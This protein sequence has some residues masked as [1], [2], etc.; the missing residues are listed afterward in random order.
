MVRIAEYHTS[1]CNCEGLGVARDLLL[2]GYIS[3]AGCL[4]RSALVGHLRRLCDWHN[5]GFGERRP[6]I[7]EY[8]GRLLNDKVIDQ[9][10]AE[11]LRRQMVVGA[12]CVDGLPVGYMAV[13]ELL[14]RVRLLLTTHPIDEAECDKW[15][16]YCEQ[17]AKGGDCCCE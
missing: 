6:D 4:A 10:T 15:D 11:E 17:E 7:S 9:T 14:D 2:R 8:V 12:R 1:K 3:S 16:S 13:A 5:V